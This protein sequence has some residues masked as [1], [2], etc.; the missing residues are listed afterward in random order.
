MSS[1]LHAH[2]R[3]GVVTPRSN[4]ATIFS[5]PIY[6]RVDPNQAYEMWRRVHLQL[7]RFQIMPT[8]VGFCMLVKNSILRHFGLFDAQYSPGYNEENDFAC[9]INR[10][11]FSCVAANHAFVFHFESSTFGS[12]KASLEKRNRELLDRRYPEYAR[13]VAQYMRFDIDPI[14]NF[15][16]LSTTHRKRILYDLTHLPARHSGTSEFALSLLAQLAPM[17][18]EKY[19]LFL[20]L[21]PEAEEFFRS[22]LVGY[23]FF[24]ASSAPNLVFD[25]AFKP[26]Q[27]FHWAEL[28]RL[29]RRAPRICYTHLDIIAVRCEYLSG[30]SVKS[31]FRTSAQLA[32]QVFTISGFSRDDFNKFYGESIAFQVVHLGTSEVESPAPRSNGYVLVVGNEF[33]HKAIHQA[34]V[35]LAGCGKLVALGGDPP[36]NRPGDNVEWV[37]SGGLGRAEMSALYQNSSVV[38]YPSFYEGFGLPILDALAMGRPVAVIDTKVNRELESLTLDPNLH[39]VPTHRDLRPAV[40]AILADVAPEAAPIPHRTWKEV[41]ADYFKFLSALAERQIDVPLV[42][43]RWKLLTTIDSICP[44]T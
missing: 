22:E 5:V 1:V 30:P 6:D 34:V 29:T 2:E 9:R 20:E 4:N 44:L 32:D 35:E 38:V 37:K 18:T 11:G 13:T 42:R 33:H 28:N 31:L 3:H 15:C 21:S 16:A 10:C 8:C 26:C 25:L 17:L 7:P 41:A 14:D 40:M 39:I 24:H 27:L 19:E 43:R 23:A 12:R 36:P